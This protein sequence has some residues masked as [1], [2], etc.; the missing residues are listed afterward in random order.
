M[1]Y[2]LGV[3]AE[4]VLDLSVLSGCLLDLSELWQGDVVS[5]QVLFDDR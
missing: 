2:G 4:I 1:L 5:A 3:S